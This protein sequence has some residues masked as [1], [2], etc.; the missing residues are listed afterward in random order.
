MPQ[1]HIKRP[2]ILIKH[3]TWPHKQ[4]RIPVVPF[5]TEITCKPYL[6]PVGLPEAG[7]DTG[8][9]GTSRH[10]ADHHRH[11]LHTGAVAGQ[12]YLSAQ[13]AFGQVSLVACAVDRETPEVLLTT[14]GQQSEKE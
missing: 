2:I 1:R 10:T 11:A 7:A 14:L 6:H 4:F 5:N 12:F 13:L 9:E 8:S 3:C